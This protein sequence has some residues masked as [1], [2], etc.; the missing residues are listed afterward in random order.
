M[1]QLKTV[2]ASGLKILWD[3]AADEPVSYTD[4]LVAMHLPNQSDWVETA[5]FQTIQREIDDIGEGFDLVCTP[6]GV[7]LLLPP[8]AMHSK[9]RVEELL[10]LARYGHISQHDFDVVRDEATMTAWHKMQLHQR[11]ELCI[12][13]EAHLGWALRVA[14]PPHSERTL[15]TLVE[16]D[17]RTP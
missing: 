14:P 1:Q 12:I 4:W 5:N 17:A 2:R 15:R 7:A 11:I 8:D 13:A 16:N 3:E 9:H 6:F 10:V